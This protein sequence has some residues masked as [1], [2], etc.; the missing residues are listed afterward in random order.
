MSA[1]SL[2]ATV[3]PT[4]DP[5]LF[6]ITPPTHSPALLLLPIVAIPLKSA[7]TVP[8]IVMLL[9]PITPPVLFLPIIDPDFS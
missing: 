1:S 3:I 6:P 7:E 5:I 8:E 9:Y 4:T 2:K